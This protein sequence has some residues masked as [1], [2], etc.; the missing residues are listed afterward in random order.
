[1]VITETHSS[2]IAAA[3]APY[4][5]GFFLDPEHHSRLTRT[6]G[7]SLYFTQMKVGASIHLSGGWPMR[8]TQW[9]SPK[10]WG[11]DSNHTEGINMSSSK[12]PEQ[13]VA[14]IKRRFLPQ[15]EEVYAKCCERRDQWVAY[16][17][18]QEQDCKAIQE[19]FGG[20]ATL[21]TQGSRAKADTVVYISNPGAHGTITPG[22]LDVSGLSRACMLAVVAVLA[23]HKNDKR[24]G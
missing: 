16:E 9:M 10:Q 11:V 12:S 21:S 1:M 13:M 4:L 14:D 7:A 6:D 2:R 15:Y 22:R 8:G 17:N 5:P 23:K 19:A 18:N 24:E 20:G 3:V